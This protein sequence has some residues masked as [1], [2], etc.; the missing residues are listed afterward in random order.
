[1]HCHVPQAQLLTR[2]PLPS[3]SQTANIE[4]AS[5]NLQASAPSPNQEFINS[6]CGKFPSNL[7][8]TVGSLRAGSGMQEQ[9]LEEAWES[10]WRAVGGS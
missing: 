2:H 6:F 9:R 1:L 10:D 4:T 3:V 7:Y 8:M 5:C